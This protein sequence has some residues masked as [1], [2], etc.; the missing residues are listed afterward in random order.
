M[1]QAREFRQLSSAAPTVVMMIL[2][3]L[4]IFL[5]FFAIQFFHDAKHPR[6]VYIVHGGLCGGQYM[7]HSHRIRARLHTIISG[8]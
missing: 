1:G 7:R 3:N 5:S 2:I 4:W 8:I 6:L